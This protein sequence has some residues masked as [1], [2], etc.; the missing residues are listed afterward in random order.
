MASEYPLLECCFWTRSDLNLS[1]RCIP[2]RGA[3]IRILFPLS[4]ATH[5]AGIEWLFPCSRVSIHHSI[6][7][8]FPCFFISTN[9]THARNAPFPH[10]AI[11]YRQL[12][13]D[14][15]SWTR[16]RRRRRLSLTAQRNTTR[17]EGPQLPCARARVAQAMARVDG[18]DAL[19][20]VPSGLFQSGSQPEQW[21]R[22]DA[23]RH[24]YFSRAHSSESTIDLRCR[25]CF[26]CSPRRQQRGT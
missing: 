9:T 12:L 25:V 11:E 22:A 16:N 26:L 8:A 23:A 5:L 7:P 4:V 24:Q 18:P 6:S 14:S 20:P 2:H 3:G 19:P 10:R 13:T 1:M 21:C 15:E 17:S